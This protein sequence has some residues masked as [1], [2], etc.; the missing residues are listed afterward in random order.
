MSEN[1][2]IFAQLIGGIFGSIVCLVFVLLAMWLYQS[3]FDV[4]LCC[5]DRGPSLD[6][7]VPLPISIIIGSVAGVLMVR[8]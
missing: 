5:G 4:D 8:K 6:V 7:V 1:K 3:V 2:K